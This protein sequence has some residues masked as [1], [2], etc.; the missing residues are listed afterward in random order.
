MYCISCL[1]VW[2]QRLEAACG[3]ANPPSEMFV[4]VRACRG[5]DSILNQFLA[6]L[7][8]RLEV[9][10]FRREVQTWANLASPNSNIFSLSVNISLSLESFEMT[11]VDGNRFCVISPVWCVFAVITLVLAETHLLAQR[12]N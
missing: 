3:S 11:D 9:D 8:K 6:A 7:H 4:F 1:C 5:G 2:K 10:V 12:S